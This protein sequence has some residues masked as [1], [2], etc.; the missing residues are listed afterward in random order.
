[1][2]RKEKTTVSHRLDFSQIH[3]SYEYSTPFQKIGKVFS[4]KGMVYEVNLARAVIGS[5]VEFVTEYGETC[6]GEVISI[7]G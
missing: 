4:N 7:K 6:M 5:N 1:M 2:I 3:K